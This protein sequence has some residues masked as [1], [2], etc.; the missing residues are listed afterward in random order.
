MY[1]YD[2]LKKYLYVE[3][4]NILEV[5]GFMDFVGLLN[6]KNDYIC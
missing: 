4:W 6:N 5:Y 3:K 2:K 1:I